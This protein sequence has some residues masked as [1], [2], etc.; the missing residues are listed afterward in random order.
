MNS[1]VNESRC[2]F[3]S[4]PTTYKIGTTVAYCLTFVVSLVGNSFIGIVVYK[5]ASLRK[6]I[7][8]LIVNMAMS[9][10]LYPIFLIPR[11][12]S[13]LYQDSWLIT[14]NLGV[15]LCKL[16]PFLTD[17][18]LVVSVQSLIFIAVDRLGAVLFPLRPPLISSKPCAVFVFISWIVAMAV[19]SPDLFVYNLR[20]Y[21]GEL[22]CFRDWRFVGDSSSWSRYAYAMNV[23]FVYIPIILLITLYSILL[24][25]LKSKKIPGQELTNAEK[26]RMKLNRKV[27]KMTIAIVSLFVFC[28]LPWSINLVLII[29]TKGTL[30]CPFFTYWHITKVLSTLHCAVNPCICLTFSGNYRKALKDLFRPGNSGFGPSHRDVIILA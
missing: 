8:F 1:S 4:D 17:V 10:L 29:F 2:F 3:E 27:T 28:W 21:Q 25:A 9:D 5:T 15:A 30:P 11:R 7:N 12:L 22:V 6:P 26:Q 24:F 16:S 14:G 20:V 13:D 23:V 18:S 19:M